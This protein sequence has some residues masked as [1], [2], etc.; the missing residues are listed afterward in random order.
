MDPRTNRLCSPWNHQTLGCT[1]DGRHA[2]SSQ[3]RLLGVDLSSRLLEIARDKKTNHNFVV[4]GVKH[5]PFREALFPA[6]V[7]VDLLEHVNITEQLLDEVQ[8]VTARPRNPLE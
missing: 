2:L 4:A 3:A 8:R 7:C 6:I 1:Q 5:L